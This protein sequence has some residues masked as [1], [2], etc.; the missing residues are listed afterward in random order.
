MNRWRQANGENIRLKDMGAR[1]LLNSISM[2]K[3]NIIFYEEKANKQSSIDAILGCFNAIKKQKTTLY[4]LIY[5]AKKRNLD[6]D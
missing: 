6:I 1:H 3:S 2:I 4:Y 5:E